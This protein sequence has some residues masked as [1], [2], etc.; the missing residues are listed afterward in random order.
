MAPFAFEDV[1]V[2][3]LLCE[4]RGRMQ[5]TA[6]RNS[7]ESAT[8]PEDAAMMIMFLFDNTIPSGGGKEGLGGMSGEGVSG[9]GVAGD[10]CIGGGI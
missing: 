7:I 6:N 3:R 1:F 9:D 4:R 8:T 10:G 5:T 2:S